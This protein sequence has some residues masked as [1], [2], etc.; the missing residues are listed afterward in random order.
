MN[1]SKKVFLPWYSR[2]RQTYL[3]PGFTFTFI[4]RIIVQFLY[5]DG[6]VWYKPTFSVFVPDV[7]VLTGTKTKQ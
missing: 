2:L 3:L 1:C 7:T 4:V 5:L 6:D